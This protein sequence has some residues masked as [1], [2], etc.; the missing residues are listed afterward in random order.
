[1]PLGDAGIATCTVLDDRFSR[2]IGFTE[3]DVERLLRQAGRTDRAEEIR[4]RYGGYVVGTIRVY[5]PWDVINHL[6]DALKKIILAH[7]EECFEM[8]GIKA[9]E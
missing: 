2:H 7:F 3:E 1:M 9:N 8:I 6:D 5:C 4:S